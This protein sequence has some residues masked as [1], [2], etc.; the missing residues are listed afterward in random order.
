MMDCK[1]RSAILLLPCIQNF[2]IYS[3]LYE[4]ETCPPQRGQ[5]Q[6][7]F[8]SSIEHAERKGGQRPHQATCTIL[9]LLFVRPGMRRMMQLETMMHSAERTSKSQKYA[10]QREDDREARVPHQALCKFYVGLLVLFYVS[11]FLCRELAAI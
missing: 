8:N 6:D 7:G 10:M 11:M 1:L 3:Q 4:G 9:C 2:M 5:V